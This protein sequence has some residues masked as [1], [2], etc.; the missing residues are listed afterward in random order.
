[1]NK[2]KSRKF[3][4]NSSLKSCIL[5]NWLDL[6]YSLIRLI[7]GFGFFLHAW[8]KLFAGSS[9]RIHLANT[10]ESYG[11]APSIFNHI[12]V[13]PA[14]S[15]VVCIGI[16]EL[17]G[18]LLLIVG[19]RVRSTACVM[20]GYLLY[21]ILLVDPMISHYQLAG[22]GYEY[23]LLWFFLTMCL[24]ISGSGKCSIDYWLKL[25][26]NNESENTLR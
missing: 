9:I 13:D 23:P 10:F 4:I 7:I 14:L 2:N 12:G 19:L 20:G 26:R 1:M 22:D 21:V 3:F 25:R 11:F 6:G 24:A 18:G 5:T 15:M 16:I 8:Q 17:V